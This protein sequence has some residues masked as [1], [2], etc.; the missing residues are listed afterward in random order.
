MLLY[1]II[2]KKFNN[3]PF[4]PAKIL[5]LIPY[6]LR[7]IIGKY[8]KESSKDILYFSALGTNEQKVFLFNK[9]KS[10]TKHAYNN[11]T[12]Y[13]DYYQKHQ[14]NPHVD[15]I[16]FEDLERIPVVSKSDLLEY[17]LALRS[18]TT[19]G[20]KILS[21]TG[22]TSGTPLNFY[23][24]VQ[25]V[26]IEWAHI[27][28]IWKEQ[29]GFNYKETKLLLVGR[30]KVDN[31]V[32]FDYKRNSLRVDI[33]APFERVYERLI[34][35]FRRIKIRYIH[36]YPSAIYELAVFCNEKKEAKDIIT[37]HLKGI[38]LVSEFTPKKQRD[39]IEKVFQSPS[40][41]FYG[42]SEGCVIAHETKPFYYTPIHS[43]GFTESFKTKNEHNLIGT[44]YYNYISPLIRYNTGDII[45]E[46]SYLN[47]LL[48]SF[49][50]DQGRAGD[51][52]L[53][54]KNKKI[55]L[56]GLIF[57]R[58]HKLF[59]FCSHIQVKQIKKG[60]AQI[61]FV[62]NSP[63]N[64]SP[65]KLFDSSNVDIKFSFKAVRNPIKAPNG[66]LKLLV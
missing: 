36:G 45:S 40:F 35:S 29:I 58:H 32:E 23:A 16:R 1:D 12:F 30:S 62:C 6:S 48:K 37:K 2:F 59:D 28:H 7:P 24:P 5:S 47:G 44:N 63:L 57:G 66:K 54:A 42:H 14:F 10:I 41:L 9:M 33:Y 39:F 17:P 49:K 4:I 53:D 55:L 21:N 51:F 26:G 3:L 64:L 20:K 31:F 27:H 34:V 56:T 13:K 61:L 50:F 22:G 38:F 15:L 18:F 11:I 8:Y 46:V 60:H 19:T 25:K 43:Y 52:I 65:E